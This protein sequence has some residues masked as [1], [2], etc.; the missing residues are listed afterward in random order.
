MLYSRFQ[1]FSGSWMEKNLAYR[2]AFL[3]RVVQTAFDLSVGSFWEFFLKKKSDTFYHSRTLSKPFSAVSR[4][5]Y[6]R[7]VRKKISKL[8]IISG[9]WPKN[10]LFL[11]K[12]LSQRCQNCILRV[13]RNSLNEIFPWKKVFSFFYILFGQWAKKLAFYQLFYE[14]FSKSVFYIS[15]GAIRRKIFSIILF[16]LSNLFRTITGKKF[17]LPSSFFRQGWKNC[18]LCLNRYNLRKAFRQ[19]K[20]FSVTF[21][22]RTKTFRL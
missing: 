22:Q 7:V 18:I 13:Y 6:S 8:L 5:F 12:K 4:R 10:F 9:H 17:G 3:G 11:S 15:M 2:Q 16:R 20:L 1:F 19:K 21:G 14:G